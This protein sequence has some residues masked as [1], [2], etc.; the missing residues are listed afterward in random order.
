[1]TTRPLG[2]AALTSTLTVLAVAAVLLVA[3]AGPASAHGVGGLQPTNYETVVRGVRP[4]AAGLVA[5]SADLGGKIELRNDSATP[6]IVIGYEKE[7]YLRVGRAGVWE[8]RRS[9]A[10]YLNRSVR[11]SG[12]APGR[13]DARARPEWHRV[14]DGPV[15]RWHDHRAHW[16]DTRDAPA[17]RRDPG[18]RHVVIAD[19]RIPLRQDGHRL[20]IEGDVV[21]VPGP[22][23]WPWVLGAI[24]LAALVV[25]VSRTRRWVGAISAA[26]GIAIVSETVHVIGAWQASTASVASRLGASVYSIGGIGIAVLAL[27]WLRRRDPWAAMPAVLIAG[28]FLLVAGGLADLTTLTRSQ[29]PSTLGPGA[30]RLTVTI[31]LGIG[32]GLV[33]AA[34]WRLRAVRRPRELLPG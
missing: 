15:A 19:W 14:A 24:G 28:L 29:V 26:L 13:Y 17:V 11:P 5:A 6:V 16:M 22:S 10:V 4:P 31:A 25:A 21:W 32:T 2:R 18:A 27:V 7:P 23:P 33:I 3:S 9:P 20:A 1:M 12:A 34:A 8:N 30:A